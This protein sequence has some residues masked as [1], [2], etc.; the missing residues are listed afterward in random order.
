MYKTFME[1]DHTSWNMIFNEYPN[2]VWHKI[3]I[4]SFDP[5]DDVSS[6]V[7]TLILTAPIHFRAS[8]AETLMQRHISPNQMKKQTHVNL[9]WPEG[10]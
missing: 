10:E 9:G 6:D 2:D 1:Y 8:I 3:K 7:W 5:Y 4:D